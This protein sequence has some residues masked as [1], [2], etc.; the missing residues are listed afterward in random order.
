MRRDLSTENDARVEIQA[1]DQRR[2]A[3]A[4]QRAGRSPV[5]GRNF[6][7]QI[8]AI[9][10]SQAVVEFE[11]DGTIVTAND[12]FLRPWATR[13]TRSGPR[14]IRCS[15]MR[16]NGKASSTRSSGPTRPGEYQA[17]EFKRIGKGG[18]EVWIQG[19]YTSDPGRRGASVQGRQVRERR[20]Q[21]KLQNA[22]FAGQIAAI[23]KS[24]AVIEFQLD[25]TIITANDN[26]LQRDG[27]R[28]GRDSRAATTACSS[29]RPPP[30]PGVQGVLGP[31]G[32]RASTRAGEFKRLGKGGREVW[33]QGSYNPILDLNGRPFKVVK[34]ATDVTAQVRA[35]AASADAP[36]ASR[37][38]TPGPGECGRGADRR[39]PAD[40][41]Q[42]RGDGGPGQRRRPPP[43][44]R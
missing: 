31:A 23:G 44:S 11:L 25:G 15:S 2:T 4:S 18:R 39:Q 29:T 12:N 22:D 26:F 13:W 42:R 10:K 37:R 41:G 17:G 43:P 35:A 34:Y 16:L 7:G 24:Q 8:A 40:G 28:A 36:R 19:A 6:I 27:L 5:P 3:E 9:R 20:D 33:I 1:C 38:E 32:P 21:Q 14:T 30:E